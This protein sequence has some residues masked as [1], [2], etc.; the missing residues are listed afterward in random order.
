MTGKIPVPNNMGMIRYYLA[1]SVLINHFNVLMGTN[2]FWPTSS[3]DRLGCFFIISGFLIWRSYE[4]SGSVKNFFRRRF[5][6]ILPPYLFV[7]LFFAIVLCFLSTLSAKEYFTSGQFWKYLAAN[8]LSLNFLQPSLPGVFENNVNPAVN[9]SLWTM[10]V[11]WMLYVSVPIVMWLYKRL[12]PRPWVFFGS[13]YLLAV[14]YRFTCIWLYNTTGNHTFEIMSRQVWTQMAY[15]YIGSLLFLEFDKLM[16][17]KWMILF[18]AIGVY[19][20]TFT[21]Q[22]LEIFLR[23]ISLAC[24]VVLLSMIGSWGHWV[25]YKNNISYDLYLWHY[26]IFQIAVAIGLPAVLGSLGTFAVTV[27]VVICLS[28]FSWF[29]IGKPCLKIAKGAKKAPVQPTNA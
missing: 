7:V 25:G 20:L 9:G 15:F 12:K 4:N 27:A 26:P 18:M 28:L 14:G 13:I 29:V 24:V 17:F 2:Y 6:R 5:L 23:P 3:Y 16:K 22:Y 1:T 11:E 19:A 10:K 21:H 8:A